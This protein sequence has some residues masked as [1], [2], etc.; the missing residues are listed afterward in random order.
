MWR[1]WGWWRR[2]DSA[3]VFNDGGV[4]AH[5]GQSETV[6]A[7]PVGAFGADVRVGAVLEEKF[8]GGQVA[9]G[10]G[11]VDRMAAGVGGSDVS[12]VTDGDFEEFDFA[13]PCEL[14]E[15]ECWV[16]AVFEEDFDHFG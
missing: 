10:G 12:A 14:L 3:E 2:G 13:G 5:D 8:D 15:G 4:I 7:F 16:C 9:H 1:W 6:F 11:D